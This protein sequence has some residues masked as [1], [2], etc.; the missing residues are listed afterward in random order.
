MSRDW[1]V[2]GTKSDLSPALHDVTGIPEAVLRHEAVLADL[3]VATRM[4]FAAGRKTTRPEDRAYSLMGIFDVNMS[5][6]YGEGGERAFRRLQEE[7]TKHSPDT[8]LFAWGAAL[9]AYRIDTPPSLAHPS[10]ADHRSFLFASSP[11]NFGILFRRNIR[12][13]PYRFDE[14]PLLDMNVSPRQC[15]FRVLLQ[16]SDRFN[17]LGRGLVGPRRTRPHI[18]HHT[19][20]RSRP[21]LHHQLEGSHHRS[22]RLVRGSAPLWLNSES[23]RTPG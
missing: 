15:F 2:L 3:S 11:T 1:S 16:R 7:I 18:L 4:G 8:T 20:R 13:E 23:M 14:P 12:F 5:T 22:S 9:A 21:H 6:L 17:M 10:H 19:L